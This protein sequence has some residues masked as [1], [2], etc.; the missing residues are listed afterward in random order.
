MVFVFMR[1]QPSP[2][3]TDQPVGIASVATRTSACRPPH[4]PSGDYTRASAVVGECLL[5]C[6]IWPPYQLIFKHIKSER[7]EANVTTAFFH[8]AGF[9]AQH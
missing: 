6:A 8:A 4:R 2:T 3:H 1:S 9:D 7:E 5:L